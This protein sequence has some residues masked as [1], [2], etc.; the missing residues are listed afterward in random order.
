MTQAKEY[1]TTADSGAVNMFP[2]LITDKQKDPSTDENGAVNITPNQQTIKTEND[3]VSVMKQDDDDMN[4][5]DSANSNCSSSEKIQTADAIKTENDH[6]SVMKQDDE[7]MSMKDGTNR[8]CSSSQK[9]HTTD[10]TKKEK[11]QDMNIQDSTHD[12]G[13]VISEGHTKQCNENIIAVGTIRTSHKALHNHKS[14][15]IQQKRNK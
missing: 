12:S 10:T 4:L 15:E 14:L 5:K 11:D 13:Y 7:D 9:I 8:N 6:V 1:P 3:H 2:E